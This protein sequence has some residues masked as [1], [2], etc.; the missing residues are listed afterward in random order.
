MHKKQANGSDPP[1]DV[2]RMDNAD[3][4]VYLPTLWKRKK[5]EH[6]L[7]QAKDSKQKRKQYEEPHGI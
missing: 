7:T 4:L 1:Q 6:F 5:G 2:M 3:T